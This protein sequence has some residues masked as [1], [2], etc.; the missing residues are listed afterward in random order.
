MTATPRTGVTGS[1]EDLTNAVGI[2]ALAALGTAGI[3]WAAARAT[4]LL[5]N[6][7]HAGASFSRSPAFVTELLSSRNPAK[8]WAHAYPDAPRLEVGLFWLLLGTMILGVGT[9]CA[10]GF[11]LWPH[12]RRASTAEPARWAT[13]RDEQKIAV[14]RDPSTRRWR[15]TAGLGRQSRRLLA[16]NDCV[17]AVVFGP[18]GSG[19]TTSLIVPNV[20]DWDGPVVL[21]T[22]K[23]QDLEPICNARAAKG[24]AWVIAP[25]G[26]TG[27]PPAGWSPIEGIGDA[28]T[29]DRVAEWMVES[30]GMTADAKA[31]PWN[32][33][34]RKYLKGLL[35]A[36]AINGGGIAQW[37]G[38]IHAGERARD[39]VE[40]ILR[41][42]G[43][44]ASAREYASTWQI[45]EEGKGSV[46]FTAL[47]LADTYSRP[48]ILTAA[49]RGGFTPDQLLSGQGTLCIVTPNAEGDRFAPYFTALLSA[50][51]HQAETAAAGNGGPI[52]PRLLLALDE[53]GNVF[54]YP[55]LAHLL[56]TARGNGIQLLLIFHDLAQVEHLYGGREVA[57]TVMS[58]AKM[59]MLLPGVADLDTLRYWSD[60][61]GH[62]RTE[63]TGTTTGFD[64]KR[65]RSR[66][67][68]SDH[69]APLHKL[70]QLP[71]GQAVLLYENLPP[72]RV[73]L[74]PWYADPRFRHLQTRP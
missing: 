33:Q 52:E 50:I 45:H 32:A 61:I 24:P 48:G 5:T 26:A 49:E 55:R 38:W 66:N 21:T 35:L 58:N 54:R 63:T 53:A 20:L 51:I 43:H 25:G 40:D 64:G 19:K 69:L 37:V 30:S 72:A 27:H 4:L 36:A 42:A 18:N 11:T 47:G 60:L 23:A 12:Q 14:R 67:E 31:R 7:S 65:S 9:M 74:L 3:C 22:A 34:A 39:H 10:V 68:H 8:A 2:L 46:L 56:T 28:E 1:N 62:T 57:R 17:S 71:A 16:G 29:A 6:G 73:R 59:R 15:L 41:G 44:D 70:Q 13:R